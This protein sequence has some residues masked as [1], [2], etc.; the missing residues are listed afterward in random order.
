MYLDFSNIW[1][2]KMR[3]KAYRIK[4]K[5]TL[6]TTLNH[7]QTSKKKALED[8]NRVL[9]DYLNDKKLN[10]LNLFDDNI[11]RITYKVEKKNNQ[12]KH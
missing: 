9:M 2:E 7:S 6:E 5:L 12:I 11:P 10:I 4:I 1:E 8:V 3:K